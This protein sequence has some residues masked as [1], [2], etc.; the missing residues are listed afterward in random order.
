VPHP[1]AFGSR[2][3]AG[4]FDL[5]LVPTKPQR[6]ANLNEFVGLLESTLAKV[7]QNKRL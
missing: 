5:S 3:G 2:K 1:C 7:Y 4:G 6:A